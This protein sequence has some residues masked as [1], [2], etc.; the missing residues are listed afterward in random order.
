MF[1]DIPFPFFSRKTFF[2]QQKQI[3]PQTEIAS[4]S[5]IS[6]VPS[7]QLSLYL[8][9]SFLFPRHRC[10]YPMSCRNQ[11]E[12]RLVYLTLSAGFNAF[13]I[14]RNI[15]FKTSR[16]QIGVKCSSDNNAVLLSVSIPSRS[17][18]RL[19]QSLLLVSSRLDPP[20]VVDDS[21]A[22]TVTFAEERSFVL[23]V[24]YDE[25]NQGLIS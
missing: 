17:L 18:V 7:G 20:W 25:A 13:H 24:V 21:T 14:I 12:K 10:A 1:E 11:R 16:L 19:L 4:A 23:Q 3:N 5:F 22:S 2:A 6:I 15:L 8:L 9:G